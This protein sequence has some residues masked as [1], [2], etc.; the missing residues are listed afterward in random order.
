MVRR[1]NGVPHHWNVVSDSRDLASAVLLVRQSLR[2]ISTTLD[3]SPGLAV[4]LSEPVGM[5]FDQ[6]NLGRGHIRMIIE[7]DMVTV[8][9]MV[10]KELS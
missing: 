10:G 9:V 1:S 5:E 7:D 2:N 8:K 6:M 4:R 3:T